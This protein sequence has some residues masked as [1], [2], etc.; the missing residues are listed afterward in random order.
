MD[1]IVANIAVLSLLVF[2]FAA[3]E[4]RNPDERLLCWVGGWISILIHFALE[5]WTPTRL[6]WQ[7]MEACL[8]LDTLAL[9]AIFFAVSTMITREGKKAGFRLG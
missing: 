9:A 8:S 6:V 2:L 7:T 3:I 5:L 1:Q 4:Q